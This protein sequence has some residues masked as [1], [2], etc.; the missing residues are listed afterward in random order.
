MDFEQIQKMNREMSEMEFR[1]S[2]QIPMTE[3]VQHLIE[4][5]DVETACGQNLLPKDS[6]D[7][8]LV[9][10]MDTLVKHNY[11]EEDAQEAVYDATASLI[12]EGVL[13]DTPP[14]DAEE[15]EKLDWINRFES[16]IYGKLVELGISFDDEDNSQVGTNGSVH[17]E[18]R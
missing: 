2:I 10:W 5:D 16:K 11:V 8:A 7:Q 17:S 3:E 12:N 13:P 14:T 15:T 1:E 18:D 6:V 9:R 4:T